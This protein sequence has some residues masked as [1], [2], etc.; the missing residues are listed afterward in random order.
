V[1]RLQELWARVQTWLPVRAWQ[2]YGKAHG[3]VLAAGM[4]YF[5]FFALAPMLAVGFT[6]L[7]LVLG[8][9]PELQGEVV[10]TVNSSLGTAV[11]ADAPGEPGMVTID[12]LTSHRALGAASLI[13][14]LVLLFSAL[15]WVGVTREGVRA[16]FG[17][18]PGSGNI[19]LL[20]LRD[21]LALLLLGVAVIASTIAEVSAQTA[22][23]Q[24]LSWLGMEGSRA[25]SLS[26]RTLV[27]LATFL[28]DAA[29]FLALFR[30]L[31]GIRVPFRDLLPAALLAA[32]GLALLKLFGGL[33]LTRT[34]TDQLLASVSGVVIGLLIWLN[35]IGRLTLVSAA[36]AAT[37]SADRGHLALAATPGEAEPAASQD[38]AAAQARVAVAA[39]P[40][41]PAGVPPPAPSFGRR[42][43]DRTAIAAGAV[44]GAGALVVARVLGRAGRSLRD[45]ATR[46][47]ASSPEDRNG[48]RGGAGAPPRRSAPGGSRIR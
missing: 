47:H 23:Q 8:G 12:Q 30:L 48:G 29:F 35:L 20:R 37:M 43:E 36:L 42:A 45:L 33:L 7:G 40:G 41:G 17:Q 5:A 26:V 10:D 27:T 24:V 3:N 6:V 4:A 19:V 15:G 16:V 38:S 25:G 11:I 13:A 34:S 44:L 9:R 22:T 39:G 21:V 28:V 14:L 1:N 2:R 31:P 32:F 46:P 18:P